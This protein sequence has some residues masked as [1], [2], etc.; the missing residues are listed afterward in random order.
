MAPL[1][2]G[3]GVVSSS[4]RLVEAAGTCLGSYKY[5]GDETRDLQ[6]PE[7]TSGVLSEPD[8]PSPRQGFPGSG[9]SPVR[10]ASRLTRTPTDPSGPVVLNRQDPF[11]PFPSTTLVE[12]ALI[13]RGSS[14]LN[15]SVSTEDVQRSPLEFVRCRGLRDPNWSIDCQPEV[16]TDY[17]S[18]GDWSG[19]CP[20]TV[21]SLSCL[22]PTLTLG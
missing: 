10:R 3:T 16:L 9:R 21:S 18:T 8:R 14:P 11:C 15:L 12:M 6:V 5:I 20:V 4:R 17:A 2:E 1:G 13:T 19:D 7:V 22:F